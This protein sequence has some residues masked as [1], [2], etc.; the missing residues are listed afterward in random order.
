M[1]RPCDGGGIGET[2]VSS[3][4]CRRGE[5]WFT[6][7]LG[8]PITIAS[9][10]AAARAES[11]RGTNGPTRGRPRARTA[12]GADGPRRKAEARRREARKTPGRAQRSRGRSSQLFL[13]KRSGTIRPRGEN[14]GVGE[15]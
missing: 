6:V 10:D 4:F 9:S 13:E 7:S 2:L 3:R 12:Q 14:E 11:K 1:R 8:E 5:N 15:H